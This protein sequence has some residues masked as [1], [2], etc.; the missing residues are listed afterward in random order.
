[1][2]KNRV[3]LRMI[4]MATIA[5][6]TMGISGC[7][8]YER[9]QLRKAGDDIGSAGD[10]I[11]SASDSAADRARDNTADTL[12]NLGN[13]IDSNNQQINDTADQIDKN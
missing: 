10:H 13:K 4:L 7:D 11:G 9:D 1:M 8:E 5:G 3:P 2:F 6:A 12:R